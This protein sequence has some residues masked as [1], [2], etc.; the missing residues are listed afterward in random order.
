MKTSYFASKEWRGKNAV[1]ISKGVPEWYRGR[2][3]EKLV[4]PWWMV[5]MSDEEEYEKSYRRVVLSKLDPKEVFEELGEDA[6]LL[7]WETSKDIASG[8]IFCHRRIVAR[9][10]EEKLG[11]IVEE[12][13]STNEQRL[14]QKNLFEGLTL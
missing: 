13:Q 2:V 10:L 9:W 12:A 6:I 1:A 7:C 8:K 3:Y 4:P 11:V 5:N 14:E